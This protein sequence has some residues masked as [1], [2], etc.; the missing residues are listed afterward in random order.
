MFESLK[1]WDTAIFFFI[2][3]IHNDFFDFLMI[4]ISNKY[5]WI[6][7]YIFLSYLII[8][9][10]GEKSVLIIIIAILMIVASDQLSTILFKDTIKRYRPTHNI[11]IK[12]MVHT[13]YGYRGG[14]YGFISSHA[15]NSFAIM[16]FILCIL[17]RNYKYLWYILPAYAIMIAYSRIYLGVHYPSDIICGA[18]FGSIIAFIFYLIYSY[19]SNKVITKFQK[20]N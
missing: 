11:M 10:F 19:F 13:V 12:D 3:S 8:K 7:F 18:L 20:H 9:Q 4:W 17:K 15:A 16:T 5:I 2:N 1:S 14:Q 6:P